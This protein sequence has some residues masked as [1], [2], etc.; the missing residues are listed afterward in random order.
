MVSFIFIYINSFSIWVVFIFCSILNYICRIVV[1]VYICGIL[2]IISAFL[3]LIN[4]WKRK[5]NYRHHILDYNVFELFR[6]IKKMFRDESVTFNF[7]FKME[8]YIPN[9]TIEIILDYFISLKNIFISTD[10]FNIR[11]PSI[12]RNTKNS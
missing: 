1:Y 5:Y 11:L 8:R 4:C 7:F 2:L 9:R 6:N 10:L 12:N 3:Q